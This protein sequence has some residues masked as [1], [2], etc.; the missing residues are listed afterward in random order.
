MK[1]KLIVRIFVGLQLLMVVIAIAAP[2][3]AMESFGI[4]CSSAMAVVIQFSIVTQLMV[5]VITLGLPG[6]L[7]H[8]L[9]KAA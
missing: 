8:R 9:Y 2:E 7:G 6:W 4:E 3:E 5:V 1:L